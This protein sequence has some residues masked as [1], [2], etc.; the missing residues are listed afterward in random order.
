[1]I[2]SSAKHDIAGRKIHTLMLVTSKFLV[3][4]AKEF[5]LPSTITWCMM[6]ARTHVCSLQRN[7][8]V[9]FLARGINQK[10]L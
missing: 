10:Q 3:Y 9:F 1:M 2:L 4:K 7:Y 6:S 5:K 8:Q